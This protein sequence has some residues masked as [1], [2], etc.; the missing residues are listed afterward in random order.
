VADTLTIGADARA[1]YLE[2]R[3]HERTVLINLGTTILFLADDGQAS[4]LLTGLPLNPGS[5]TVWDADRALYVACAT[6]GTLL[7]S[8]NAAGIWD[9]TQIAAQIA[10]YGAPPIDKPTLVLNQTYATATGVTGSTGVLDLIQNTSIMLN[11]RESSV[12]AGLARY[13]TLNWCADAAGTI[14]IAF[15]QVSLD[16]TGSWWQQQENCRSPYLSISWGAV[17]TA[18]NAAITVQ[19]V[20]SLRTVQMRS[21]TRVGIASDPGFVAAGAD[22]ASGVFQ[23]YDGAIPNG[24]TRYAYP[25]VWAGPSHLEWFASGA[26]F[27]VTIQEL[28]TGSKIFERNSPAGELIQVTGLFMPRNTLQVSIANNSGG[29]GGAGLN[30]IMDRV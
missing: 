5:N 25:F 24:T 27:L 9:P 30:I 29:V 26:N 18:G 7:V 14:P 22:G 16:V 3:P 2:G 19:L 1:I 28:A 8:P 12:G 6:T 13:L 11:W 17:A 10:V 4:P 15:E 20:G 21:F 23:C